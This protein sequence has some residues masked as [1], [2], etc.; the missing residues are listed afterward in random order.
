MCLSTGSVAVAYE[1]QVKYL[2]VCR[3]S[4]IDGLKEFT[5]LNL[6]GVSE[7]SFSGNLFSQFP[8]K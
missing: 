2:E 4:V 7:V 3:S 5:L 1:M 6:N 8:L